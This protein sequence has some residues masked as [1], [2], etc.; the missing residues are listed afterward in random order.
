VA[1]EAA[2]FFEA[3]GNQASFLWFRFLPGG[4]TCAEQLGQRVAIL[5]VILF[6]LLG[7][8]EKVTRNQFVEPAS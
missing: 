6:L 3:Q 2:L 7:V 1:A 4:A 5:P 8:N